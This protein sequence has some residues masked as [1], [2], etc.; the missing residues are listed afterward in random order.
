[1]HPSDNQSVSLDARAPPLVHCTLLRGALSAE[2][3]YAEPDELDPVNAGG[4]RA[5]Q[6]LGEG[7][8]VMP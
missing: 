5:V 1:M 2:M 6:L 4:R 8:G 3:A 7:H